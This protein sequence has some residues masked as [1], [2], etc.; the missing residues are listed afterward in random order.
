M[1]TQPDTSHP[2]DAINLLEQEKQQLI[3]LISHDLRSPFNRLQ[4]LIQLLQMNDANLTAD[5]KIYLEK[6]HIVV[7][8][9][10]AMMRNLMDYRSL[11][12][13]LLNLQ[14]E[15]ISVKELL[16]GVMKN[17]SGV[18]HKKEIRIELSNAPEIKITTD[19]YS[20]QRATENIVSNALKFSFGGKSVT[21]DSGV[22]DNNLWITVSDEGQ[23][24]KASELTGIGEKFKKFSARPTGGESSTGLGLYVA[25]TL[26]LRI[27]GQIK[28]QSKEGRGSTFRITLPTAANKIN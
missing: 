13:G 11:E 7:A 10:L 16:A 9:A 28:V 12:L 21:I 6:M 3:S 15:E 27:G 23:G 1:S 18:A 25:Y 24:F 20:L 8:D 4:A 22:S 19:R 2:D 17:F 14:P 5:Q 26:L